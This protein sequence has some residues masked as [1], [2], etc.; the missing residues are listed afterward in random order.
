ELET[1]L[2]RKIPFNREGIVML[3]FPGDDLAK[4]EK[5]VTFREKEGL[6]LEIW[7][8]NKLSDRCPQINCAEVK[9]AIYSPQDRQ[10][11]PVALTL[12]L[13]EAAEHN[14]V[15][16]HWGFTAENY[17]KDR[18]GNNQII[19]KSLNESLILENVDRLILAAGLG[20]LET[21]PNG[22]NWQNSEVNSSSNSS[23]LASIIDPQLQLIPVLG[24]G[25]RLRLESSL[26]RVDFQPVITGDDVH[27][28]PLGGG[29]YW[30]GATVEFPDA[31]GEVVADGSLLDGAIK[32][33]IAF[34]PDLAKATEV[35]RWSGLRPRPQGQS[36]P[37]IGFL[38]GFNN[39]LLATGHYRNGIL[40]APATAVLVREMLG[41]IPFPKSH[42]TV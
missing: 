2:N 18:G 27:I 25:A 20:S 17:Q 8:S 24:Q 14:G 32:R 21:L 23:R 11:D 6:K 28:I 37:V 4:W 40:L 12:A 31:A 3:C 22:E 5:L 26:G 19:A 1:K 13:I 42:A 9:A 33:A 35:K 29:E 10:V 7:D 41:V 38:P 30:V 36:A 15:E 34:C 16:F 39:V